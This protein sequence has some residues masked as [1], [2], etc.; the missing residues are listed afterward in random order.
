M[1]CREEE[2]SVFWIDTDQELA[3]A[4]ASWDDCVGLDT[5]FIRT[6]TFYPIPGLYQVASGKQVFLLDPL[7][8]ENWQPFC[9]FL[10]DG[11]KVKVMHACQE[12]LELINH[13]LKVAPA[14]IFDT[15]FANAF[16][17]SDY[18]L[19]YAN[20]VRQVVDVDL[21]K[22]ETRSN[23]LQRPLTEE[24]MVYAADDVIYLVPMYDALTAALSESGRLTWFGEDMARR[25]SY[26]EPDPGAYFAQVKRAW[27][28]S[29]RELA[30]LQTLCRW[31]ENAAR[32]FDMPRN[33]IVWD[34]HLMNLATREQVGAAELNELLPKAIARKYGNAMLDAH[35]KGNA[36]Q[37]PK[38]LNKPLST[39]QNAR[40]KAL[41][42]VAGE[43]AEQLGIAPELL[44]RRKD[45]EACLRYYV[46]NTELSEHYAGWRQDLVGAQFLQILSG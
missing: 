39:G 45:V 23:W 13:H 21:Q 26:V 42:S 29:E 14:N 38:P 30:R 12:D 43:K 31:R 24:Q 37:P 11:T 32:H 33:R 5:E 9:E 15:Q 35:A 18:S 10:T 3:A 2:T 25:G 46:E 16:V 40:V 8:I 28:L 22:Q 1:P 44:A 41:R 7:T 17:R 27:Q 36:A 4:V 19:S 34:D 20:L 6:D